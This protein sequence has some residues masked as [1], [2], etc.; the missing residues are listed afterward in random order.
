[1]QSASRPAVASLALKSVMTKSSL[2]SWK[3]LEAKAACREPTSDP[4][5]P[6]SI[7]WYMSLNERGGIVGVF[8]MNNEVLNDAQPLPTMEAEVERRLVRC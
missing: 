4:W 1:M 8:S 2:A 6:P 3:V 5:Q 7:I